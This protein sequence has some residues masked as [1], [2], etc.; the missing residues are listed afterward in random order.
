MGKLTIEI[1]DGAHQHLRIIAATRG[2]SIKEFVLEKLMP[3]LDS[4]RK[5]QNSLKEMADAWVE[6]SKEFKLERSGKSL[7][8]IAHEGHQW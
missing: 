6:R 7:R 2:V 4:A 8:E 3:E 5:A 1:P